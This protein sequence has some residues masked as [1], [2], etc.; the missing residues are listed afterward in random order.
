M[1]NKLSRGSKGELFNILPAGVILPFAGE[2][3]PAG[4][5]IC[6]G[7]ILNRAEYP[8]LF[9]A[10]GTAWGSPD[11]NTFNL[12]DTRGKFLRG[13]DGT[14]GLDPDKVSRTASNAG[15][16]TG[17]NVGSIQDDAFQGHSFGSNPANT[18]TRLG[19]F[20][21]NMAGGGTVVAASR[22]DTTIFY[23]IMTDTVNGTPR[24]TSET[25]VKNSNI[26]YIIKL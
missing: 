9:Q 17:N 26:N 11:A 25:R 21:G 4:W 18:N 22:T 8:E 24:V 12:P 14:A 23:P 2:T 5:A 7:T 20:G 6:D 10:I 19:Q 3:A 15:G 13:V 16:N 1:S